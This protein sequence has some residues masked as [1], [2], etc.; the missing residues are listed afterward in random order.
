MSHQEDSKANDAVIS[1]NVNDFTKTRDNV[2]TSLVNLSRAVTELQ[3]AYINHTNS[4]LNRDAPQF[5]LGTFNLSLHDSGLLGAL[6]LPRASSEGPG[7][8]KKRKRAPPDPNAPKRTLTPFFLY[9]H[10]NRAK[11]AQELGPSARPKEVSDEGARRWA[12]MP[13]SEKVLYKNIYADNLAAYKEKVKAYKAGK[14]FADE[15]AQA[16]NQ[17]Q[18]DVE[19]ATP[20]D[21]EASSSEEE[22]EESPEPVKEPT[23]PRSGKRRR[24]EAAKPA[25]ATPKEA[26]TPANKRASP[27]KK[28]RGPAA[29]KDEEPASTRKTPAT[30]NKRATKKK[31]KSE[32]GEN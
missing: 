8:K 25:A 2:I 12:T 3:A 5:D 20:S 17:L 11:I 10:N 26:S 13:A 32:A 29:K 4:V 31:R 6:G 22:E 19:G 24:S 15:N 21:D 14:S 1:V 9:M 18:Q 7:D 28:R 27:E 23:P 30:E 16:A